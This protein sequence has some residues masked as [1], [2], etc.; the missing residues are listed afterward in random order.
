MVAVRQQ[1][2]LGVVVMSLLYPPGASLSCWKEVFTSVKGS[3]TLLA[4][5]ASGHILPTI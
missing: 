3:G 2:A 5:L 1:R 4:L